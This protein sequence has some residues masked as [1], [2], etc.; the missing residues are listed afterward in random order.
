LKGWFVRRPNIEGEWNVEISSL[1]KNPENGLSQPPIL[2][3]A[4]I[5]QTYS[6]LH[7]KLTTGQSSGKFVAEKIVGNTDGSFEVVGIYANE[8]SLAYQEKSRPHQG[9]LILTVHDDEKGFKQ[10][11]GKYWTDR[12][13]SG[14]ISLSLCSRV[15]DGSE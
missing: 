15:I 1:W 3:K 11:S 13:T 14:E 12:G 6:K 9:A 2:G 4:I 8:P 10:L 7:L 5:S